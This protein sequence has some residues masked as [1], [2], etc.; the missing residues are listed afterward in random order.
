MTVKGHS[1]KADAGMLVYEIA[2]RLKLKSG[3][4][5][6]WNQGAKQ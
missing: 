5:M 2:N 3:D 6:G 4:G 1:V